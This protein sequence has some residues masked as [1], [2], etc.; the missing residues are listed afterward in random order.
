M[1]FSSYTLTQTI[2]YNKLN[3]E[4]RIQLYSIK[5][6]H[7][8]FPGGS[9]G[10]APSCNAGDPA[11]IP[12]RE[13]LLQCDMWASHC[14]GFCCGTQALGYVGSVAGAHRLSCPV[15]CEILV[16]GPGIIPVSPALAG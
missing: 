8:G 2:Y 14:N 12:G 1:D 15:F 4:V 3:A 9:D 6:A 10:K 7:Q 11:L 13:D 16:P 5:S